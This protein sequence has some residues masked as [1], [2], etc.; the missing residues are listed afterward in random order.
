MRAETDSQRKLRESVE[1]LER[2]VAELRAE[3]GQPAPKRGTMPGVERL[4]VLASELSTKYGGAEPSSRPAP[5]LT[6]IP[7]G[8]DDGR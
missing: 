2:L 8:R 6:L 7:G 3:H 1:S 5:T 4:R